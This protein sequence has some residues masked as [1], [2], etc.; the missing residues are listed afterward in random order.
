MTTLHSRM[1]WQRDFLERKLFED[2][3]DI[4]PYCVGADLLWVARSQGNTTERKRAAY[5]LG[6]KVDEMDDFYYERIISVVHEMML[7]P[8]HVG[9]KLQAAAARDGQPG[10]DI[11][12]L[13][14]SCQWETL[15]E[16][17]VKDRILV[18]G[19][20]LHQIR[21]RLKRKSSM[22]SIVCRRSILILL[23]VPQDL[24]SVLVPEPCRQKRLKRPETLHL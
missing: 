23:P 21:R 17:L 24:S 9:R 22:I 3:L 8:D 19:Y 10:S 15:A 16:F 1:H 5:I 18:R 2:Y 20:S 6:G 12:P 13:I 11:Q 7:D 14:D 4:M